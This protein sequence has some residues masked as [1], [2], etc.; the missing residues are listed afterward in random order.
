MKVTRFF[1]KCE[2]FSICSEVGDAGAIYIE[3][4][5][6][7]LMTLYQIQVKGSGRMAKIF[8]SNYIVGD[9]KTSNFGSVREFNGH[10][11]IFESYEP[12]HIFGFCTLDKNQDWNG[13]LVRESFTGDDNSWLI[14][15]D[16]EPIIN[17]TVL[18]PLDYAKLTVKDYNLSLIHI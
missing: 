3:P 4:A 18:K 6:D 5:D 8:D 14:C 7:M 13:R 1:K 9:A 11:L 15:F 10:N 17:E 16:G 12:F 2:E